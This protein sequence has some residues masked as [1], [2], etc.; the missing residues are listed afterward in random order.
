VNSLF[1]FLPI[2][3]SLHMPSFPAQQFL[4][5]HIREIIPAS[6]SLADTIASLL[7]VSSDSAYRRIRCETALTLDE[8]KLICDN[9]NISIDKLLHFNNDAVLFQNSRIDTLNYT[10]EKFLQ[11]QEDQLHAVQHFSEH[12]IIYLTKDIP[13][14]HTFCFRP[15]LAFRYFF[16]MKSI[17]QHPD[18]RNKQFTFDC[19]PP[20][21]EQMGQNITKLYYRYASVELWNTECINSIIFQMEYYREVGY[22]RS[23]ADLEEL[24]A[25]IIEAL[26]HLCRQAEVGAKFLPHENPA[27][28]K[29]NFQLYHNRIV[30]AD[31]TI[32]ARLDKK[33]VVYL[34]Y[35]VLNYMQTSNEKFCND[36]YEM[37]QN[38]I[39]R[40]TLISSQNESQR[41]RFFNDLK[42]KLIRAAKISPW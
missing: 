20:H 41:Y 18:F 10:F 7:C 13:L 11:A 34:N 22:F 9:F 31:N 29:N 36:I 35:D 40:S 12:E 25:S 39:R 19:L 23:A 14:F 1:V 27:Y 30:L 3:S 21:I 37:M 24:H 2:Y 26:E 6:I 33:Q 16:W 42:Q 4:F 28:K 5:N 15:L 38:L 17:V 32:Y 8:T